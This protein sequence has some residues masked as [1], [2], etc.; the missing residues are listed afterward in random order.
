MNILKFVGSFF[1][2][3]LFWSCSTTEQSELINPNASK[4]AVNLYNFLQAMFIGMI[5]SNR[6]M[7]SLLN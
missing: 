3:I 1:L 2:G 5:T 4:K 7:T 6:I